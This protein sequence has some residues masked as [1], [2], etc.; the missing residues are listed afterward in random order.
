MFT[1]PTIVASD[2]LTQRA[3]ITFYFNDNR[4]REYNGKKIGLHISP[5]KATSLK[6]RN[7]LLDNLDSNFIRHWKQIHTH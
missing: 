1:I 6:Q 3:Y 2:D 5:N 7:E 4:V